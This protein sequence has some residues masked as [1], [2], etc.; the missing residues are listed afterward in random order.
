MS[1]LGSAN[2][3]LKVAIVGAGPSGFYAA[4]ALINSE[5]KVEVNLLE[6]LC[7]P[8]GLVRTGVAPDHPLI[9][10]SIEKFAVMAEPKEFNYFGNVNVG[11]DISVDELKETHHAVII[12]M[13]AETDRKLGIPGEDLQGSHTATEFV[14][15]YNGHP[16]YRDRKFDLSHETAVIIGQGNVAADVARILAKTTDELKCTDISQHALDVL[17][18]SKI[19]NIYIVGRR[20][21]A[22]GAMTSKELKEF[23]DLWDCDTFVDPKDIIL[24]QASKDE[25]ADRNGRAAK[26][27]YELFCGYAEEKKPH[28]AR[29]FPWTKPYVKPKKCHI[30]FLKSPV[31]LKG[32][33]KLDTVVFEK[34]ALS[35]E[36]FKQSARGSGELEELKAGLLFRSIG[37]RGVALEGVPFHDAWGVIPNDKGRVLEDNEN[38]VV[39]P[40][41][42]TAGWIKRGPSGIIGTNKACANETIAEL[43]QDLEKLD[44]KK[45]K[46]GSKKIMEILNTNKVRYIDFIEWGVIDQQEVENGIPKGKP[47]EKFTYTDEML[48]LLT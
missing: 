3:P 48:A 15:W 25:L 6:K 41:L 14:A 42:Y 37:Y 16:E 46:L 44:D 21:P 34:N 29:Q 45:N 26:K 36:P 1:K 7:A 38:K 27:I 39:V 23:G 11:K 2:N 13:G 5:L 24:N 33:K 22:Q 12:T 35:G 20:G 10:K 9:K 18:D 32:N 19:K 47:R 40:Q 28:K 43:I 30:Q 4:D 8:Y 31:E 17:E